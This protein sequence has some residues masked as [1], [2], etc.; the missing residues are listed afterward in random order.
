MITQQDV[1][2]RT[3][4]EITLAHAV[5]SFLEIEMLACSAQTDKWYRARLRLFVAALGPDKL[6]DQVTEKDLITWW[7]SL[8]KR[9]ES[10][11]PDLS[12]ETMHGYVRA[13]RRLFKWLY[14]KHITIAELWPVLKLP[15]LP[16]QFRKGVNDNDVRAL[17]DAAVD[18][19]RDLALLLFIESTGCRRGGVANLKLS[20]LNLSE[21]APLCRRA[22]VREKGKKTREVMLS[23]DALK[24]LRAWLLVRKSKTEYVFVDVRPGHDRKLAPGGISQIIDRYKDKL[25]ITGRVSPHQWRHRFCRTLLK[26]GMPLNIVS[27]LA[28][29][30]SIV[31]TAKFYGNLLTDELQESFEKYY[32]P[33]K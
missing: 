18:N 27:Q 13:A 22:S 32:A 3:A 20:D 7:K 29:H 33:P 15:T 26:R 14:D 10:D 17:L 19:P 9:T 24:A 21:P 16:E 12:I 23:Q 31:V 2:V 5:D 8:E 30:K 4:R 28:G 25:G 6:L 1:N 11:P